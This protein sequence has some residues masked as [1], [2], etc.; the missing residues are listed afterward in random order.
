MQRR[1]FVQGASVLSVGKVFP[2]ST[3]QLSHEDPTTGKPMAI[4]GADAFNGGRSQV[5]L[6]F[7]QTGGDYPFLN[8]LKTAQSWSLLDNTGF[9][10]PSTLDADGYPTSISNGGV[11]T[12]FFVPSQSARPGSYVVTWDGNGTIY[13]GM[14]HVRVSGSK[15]SSSGRGR[16][17]FST[18]S[19]RVVLGIQQI[20]SP[21][22]TNMKVFHA[23]DEA[24]LEDGEVFG[25]R[26]KQRLLEANFGV[27]RFLNWQ[28]ANTSN[29]TTWASRKPE[30]HVFYSAS[31]FRPSLYAGV[32][33]NKGSH[34]RASLPGFKLVDKAIVIVKFNASCIGPCTLDI[35]GT[36]PVNVLNE[37]SGPLSPG[38]NSYIEGGTWR[39]LATL[40]YDDVLKSWIKFGGDVAFGSTG[41]TNG[42]PP[43][44]MVR[45]CAEVGAHPHF[46]APM[47]AVD[48]LTDYIPSLAALCRSEAP[49][50]MVPRFEGPNEL[51]NVAAGFLGSAHASAKAEAYG[52]GP[53][54]H[55][56]YGKVMS[57]LGQAVSSVYDGDRRAY[58]VLCAVQTATGGTTAGTA[59]SNARLSSAKY[60][61]QSGAAQAPYAKSPASRWVTHVCCAQYYTP[62][63]YG[64]PREE[65]Q[66]AQYAK[67]AGDPARQAAIANA[68]ASTSDRGT[69]PFTLQRVADMYVN[70]K[71]WALSFGVRSM[72]GYEGGYSPDL[73]GTAQVRA[74]R[75]ASKRAECLEAFTSANY[76][77]FLSLTT[78]DFKAEFP[79][80]FQLSGRTPTDNAWSVLDDVY[81]TPEPPQWRAIVAFNRRA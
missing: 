7:L 11:Y 56:W 43:K 25:S 49:S 9:P 76:R 64:S 70:W 23:K 42:C 20:G 78:A 75:T 73:G 58:Q 12:V 10:L 53:D 39:S 59:R 18:S 34:Y 14:D 6:N 8:C 79:S 77:N 31:E 37:Y 68:Y 80:C 71:A 41:I 61:S 13:L 50:W 29:V 2:A 28:D 65:E 60:V 4:R 48:P 45:L 52:W 38:S 46:I 1:L 44:L 27:I 17:V 67:A 74:L 35:S 16:F 66:A 22:I 33:S 21:H 40:V 62:S 24:A 47:L 5:N 19:A 69:G 81:E 51:W 63:D 57:V 15:S 30:S 72:C 32:T 26:F 3:R 55:N 36:G 54:L